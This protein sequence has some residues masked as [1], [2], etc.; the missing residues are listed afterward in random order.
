MNKTRVNKEYWYCFKIV[1]LYFKNTLY[2]VIQNSYRCITSWC[3][4]AHSTNIKENNCQ[5]TYV[6]A[7]T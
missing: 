5:I 1:W 4:I 2:F 6:V 7:T 3:Q